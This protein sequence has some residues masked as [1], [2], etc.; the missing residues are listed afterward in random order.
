MRYGSVMTSKTPR[1]PS[2]IG[3][4]PITVFVPRHIRDR[5]KI[6]AA[7]QGRPMQ[8]MPL[9]ALHDLFRKYG[10]SDEAASGN[11]SANE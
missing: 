8:D 6:L 1:P 2:R 9:E 5:L 7:E 10:A 11:D 3:T 4:S